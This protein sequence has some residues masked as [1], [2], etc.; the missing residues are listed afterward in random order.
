MKHVAICLILISLFLSLTGCSEPLDL[1]GKDAGQQILSLSS[2]PE[3]YLGRE[4]VFAG[5]Y[6]VE[7]FGDTYHY[8]LLDKGTDGENIGFEI[9]WDGSY[10]A[11]GTPVKVRGI[12]STVTEYGQNYI[13]LKLSE[14]TV[15]KQME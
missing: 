7:E 9:R 8:V 11:P 6:T 14:L 4:I 10:P 13:Y 15:L 5:Y 1:T 3:P 12:L 2:D